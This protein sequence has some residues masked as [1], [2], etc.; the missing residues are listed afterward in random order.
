MDPN[1]GRVLSVNVGLPRTFQ[2]NGRTVA[3]AIW[4]TPVAGRIAAR[5]VNLEGDDQ[6]DRGA[7]GGPD[8]A[9][10]AYA[11]EDERSWERELN[12]PFPAGVFGENLTTEG[13]DVNGARIGERWEIGTVVLEVSE[14]RVP[15]W[16]L[17]VRMNDSLFPRR[18]TEALRPGA[19]LRI[20]TEGQLGAGDAIRVIERPESP[21]TVRDVF[22]IYTRDQ[23]EAA[24]LIENPGMSADWKRWAHDSL[25][26]ARERRAQPSPQRPG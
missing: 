6:A 9:V 25:R 19:Y 21:L 5:G 24:R 4:K 22:R 1:P 7:H 17:G 20:I 13:I 14:P 8:K 26:H 10:Y 12:R 23:H 16:R 11:V 2:F 15:C 18:L 3:S